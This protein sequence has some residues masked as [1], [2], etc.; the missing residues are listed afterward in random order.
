MEKQ[1]GKKPH[2]TRRVDGKIILRW[3]MKVGLKVVDW[4]RMAQNRDT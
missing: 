4:I 2:G 3:V 1:E